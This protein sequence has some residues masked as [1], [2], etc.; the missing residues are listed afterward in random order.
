MAKKPKKSSKKRTAGGDIQVNRARV[1][2]REDNEILGIVIK[3][4]GNERMRV[5]CADGKER[6]GRI[7]GKLK[8]RMWVRLGDLVLVSPWDFQD[9]R[10][11]IIHRY[12]QTES[13]WL[14]RKGFFTEYLDF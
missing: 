1:P 9:D 4:L 10:C 13:A 7:R 6:L 5:R 3:I 2:R 14:E 12:R 8:K 11:D